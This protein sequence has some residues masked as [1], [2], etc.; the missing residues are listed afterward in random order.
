MAKKLKQLDPYNPDH[1]DQ[2]M[3]TITAAYM[4]LCTNNKAKKKPSNAP[5]PRETPISKWIA[6]WSSIHS[7]QFSF[8]TGRLRKAHELRSASKDGWVI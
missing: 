7:W 4:D 5:P 2:V 3:A 1:H 8:P 6:I